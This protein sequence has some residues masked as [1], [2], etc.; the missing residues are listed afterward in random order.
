MNAGRT[1]LLENKL[2]KGTTLAAAATCW[3]R[4][5]NL[6]SLIQIK[7]KV[8]ASG[9]IRQLNLTISDGLQE[10]LLEIRTSLLKPKT[11][12]IEEVDHALHWNWNLQGW[13]SGVLK[14]YFPPR[15]PPVNTAGGNE[16]VSKFSSDLL[17]RWLDDVASLTFVH[18]PC[19]TRH[20]E[21]SLPLFPILSPTLRTSA[22]RASFAGP[23]FG[24]AGGIKD[25]KALWGH[26][27]RLWRRVWLKDS[28]R[29]LQRR[30]LLRLYGIGGALIPK[31]STS[32]EVFNKS[33]KFEKSGKMYV[34][35]F[36]RANT[37]QRARS[38]EDE[39]ARVS[40]PD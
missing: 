24:F 34:Y 6:L 18:L 23:G 7:W 9:R 12:R 21:L 13:L 11:H 38:T 4:K 3:G 32:N 16:V 29:S 17:I 20:K 10:K 19:L 25:K 15:K 36:T 35:S 37:L 28:L 2:G 33:F 14:P 8:K 31:R 5:F 40:L 39:T 27:G 22:Q 26:C 30:L 1:C